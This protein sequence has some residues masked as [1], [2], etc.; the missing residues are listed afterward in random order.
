[1]LPISDQ[2]SIP[3]E[4]IE[5]HAIRAQGAGGQNVNK[6]ASAIHLRFNIAA[7]SL[8]EPVKAQLFSLR[9]KRISSDGEIIIKAQRYRTQ[10]RNR[11]DALHRLQALIQKATAEQRPRKPTRRSKASIKR[12]LDQKSRRSQLKSMRR[13]VDEG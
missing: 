12:R 11:E 9:D 3:D 13:P 4:E 6:V 2:L 7:S 5:M 8:P 1:M 10:E